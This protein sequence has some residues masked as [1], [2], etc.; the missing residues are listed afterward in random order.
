MIVEPDS[1]LAQFCTMREV[2]L[3]VAPD[4]IEGLSKAITHLSENTALRERMA[5]Q[6]KIV[7]EEMSLHAILSQW[8]N[9]IEELSDAQ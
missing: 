9:M 8:D 2:A 5:T 6:V 7:R 1:A 3:V 4:D